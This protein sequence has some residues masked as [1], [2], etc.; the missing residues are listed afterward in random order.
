MRQ[1][2]RRP[3]ISVESPM[4]IP[5]IVLLGSALV[6][7]SC[8]SFGPANRPGPFGYDRYAPGRFTSNGQR[9]YFT[10]TGENGS[11]I[12]YSGG[13]RTG[14]MMMGAYLTCA[15]C[16]GADG[17]GGVHYVHMESIDAPPIY[18]E[19]LMGMLQEESDRTPPPTTYTVDDLR[20]AVV[21]GLHPDGDKLDIV[22]PRWNMSDADLADLLDF[23][24]TLP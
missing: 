3:F 24:K 6:L 11:A 8:A 12:S 14:G 2:P 19:A 1:H 13:P 20:Q 9:I 7:S 18:Y 17:R 16:H 23:L 10:A 4:K 15:A 5:A 21:E 22:M